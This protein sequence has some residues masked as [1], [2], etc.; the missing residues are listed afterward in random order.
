L[1][2]SGYGEAPETI[3]NEDLWIWQSLMLPL[4]DLLTHEAVI[5]IVDRVMQGMAEVVQV[6]VRVLLKFEFGAHFVGQLLRV[7]LNFVEGVFGAIN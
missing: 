6:R 4:W 1:P 3:S 5:F 2:N 7:I